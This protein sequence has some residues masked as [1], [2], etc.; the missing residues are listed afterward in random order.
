MM[1]ISINS[2]VTLK[3]ITILMGFDHRMMFIY[4]L[5]NFFYETFSTF[6]NHTRDWIFAC[7]CFMREL[8][9]GL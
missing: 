9:K 5:S 4:S 3:S 1:D 2:Q 6:I 8:Q 7:F